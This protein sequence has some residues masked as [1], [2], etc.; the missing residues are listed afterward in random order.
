[1]LNQDQLVRLSIVLQHAYTRQSIRGNENEC[2]RLQDI[3]TI[4]GHLYTPYIKAKVAT[5]H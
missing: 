2:L 1:M 4:L 5:H 3:H